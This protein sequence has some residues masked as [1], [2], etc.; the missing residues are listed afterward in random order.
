MALINLALVDLQYVGSK[1]Q[2]MACVKRFTCSAASISFDIGVKAASMEQTMDIMNLAVNKGTAGW[3]M[4]TGYEAQNTKELSVLI[5]LDLVVRLQVSMKAMINN[6]CQGGS[7]VTGILTGDVKLM[8]Q[9]LDSDV[10]IEPVRGPLIPG[11][12]AVKAAAKAAGA[13]L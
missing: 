8:G 13:C 11:M 3:G 9:S 4:D 1:V 12:L 6:C 5:H 2:N 7:L 10:I